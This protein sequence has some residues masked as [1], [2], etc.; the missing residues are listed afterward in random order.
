MQ[1]HFILKNNWLVLILALLIFFPVS[2]LPLPVCSFFLNKYDMQYL[3]KTRQL[4]I[5]RCMNHEDSISTFPMIGYAHVGCQITLYSDNCLCDANPPDYIYPNLSKGIGSWALVAWKN[6]LLRS[7]NL[8]Y[9][10][11]D[12]IPRI[13]MAREFLEREDWEDWYADS[14]FVGYELEEGSS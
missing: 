3:E 6:S 10:H 11:S 5:L 8:R 9:D 13:E 1:H 7:L 12:F 14:D 4:Q 2:H